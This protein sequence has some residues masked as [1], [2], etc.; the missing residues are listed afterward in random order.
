VQLPYSITKKLR[1]GTILHL[2][3]V[4]AGFGVIFSMQSVF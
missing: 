4:L 3:K 2:L 1:P